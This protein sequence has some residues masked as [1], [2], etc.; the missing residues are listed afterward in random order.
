[1]ASRAVSM[2]LKDTVIGRLLSGDVASAVT[3]DSDGAF[4]IDV[5]IAAL[6]TAFDGSFAFG[7]ARFF[8]LFEVLADAEMFAMRISRGKKRE[9]NVVIAVFGLQIAVKT[10]ENLGK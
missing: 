5:V 8:V 3:A 1:M 4:A 10:Y 2:S 7:F 9:K 6:V